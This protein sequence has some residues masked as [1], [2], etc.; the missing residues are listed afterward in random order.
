MKMGR[1]ETGIKGR[2]EMTVTENLSAKAIGSGAL[3]VYATPAM[4]ALIEETA[5]KSIQEE[6]DEGQ[7]S[8]GTKVNIS[9]LSATPVGKKVWCETELIEIDRRRLVFQAEVYDEAGKIG[10]GT[11]ER[12]LV[13]NASFQEKASLKFS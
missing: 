13:D 7:G 12:F 3:Q 4:I 2:I 5:W 8:V 9:H 1:L 11:H 10:T 6:L